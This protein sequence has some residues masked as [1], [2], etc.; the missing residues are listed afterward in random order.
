MSE[1]VQSET[2][3]FT[4]EAAIGAIVGAVFGGLIENIF[5]GQGA[6]IV[7]AVLFGVAGAF[8]PLLFK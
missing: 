5:I 3:F 6:T 1:P 4:K 2:S 7:A 8:V